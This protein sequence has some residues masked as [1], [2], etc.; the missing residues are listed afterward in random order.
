MTPSL[1]A[2]PFWSEA[3]VLASRARLVDHLLNGGLIAYPTETVYGFGGSLDPESVEA[4]VALKR[5]PPAKPFLILVSGSDMIERLDLRLT[6]EAAR[7]AARHWP[8]PLTLVLAGGDRRV[9]AR[10]RGPEGG[11]AVRW[12]PHAGLGSLIQALGQPITSTSANLPGLPPATSASEILNDWGNEI[13]RG[14]LLVLDG[15]RLE[16]SEPSTVV[17][18]T[19]RRPRVIRP[20]AISAALLRESVPDL[21]GDV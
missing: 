1:S 4:L 2:V 11:V 8:G 10:L 16:P 20:G 15:G 6:P 13:A 18:C 14:T 9:P 5:R 12:T 3:E 19:G 21:V 17:D 7:L